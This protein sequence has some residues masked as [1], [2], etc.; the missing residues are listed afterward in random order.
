VLEPLPIT[1]VLTVLLLAR[2]AWSWLDAGRR[3]RVAVGA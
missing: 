2:P 1:I 3:Q